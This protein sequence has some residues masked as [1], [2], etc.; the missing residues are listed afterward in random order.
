[1]ILEERLASSTEIARF[2]NQIPTA[3]IVGFRPEDVEERVGVSAYK[4]RK[5]CEAFCRA[6]AKSGIC[7][8]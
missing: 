6:S 7:W 3:S 5:G 1:M 8:W 2:F 4:I